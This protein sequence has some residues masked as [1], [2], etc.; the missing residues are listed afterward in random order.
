MMAPGERLELVRQ[1]RAA[2]EGERAALERRYGRRQLQRLL[3]E[4]ESAAWLSD[5]SERCPRCRT[6]IEV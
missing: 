2:G 4:V 3:E 6:P 5:H 1:Y